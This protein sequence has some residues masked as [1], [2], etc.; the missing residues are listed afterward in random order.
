MLRVVTGFVSH[1]LCSYAFV[2]GLPPDQVYAEV[3][4]PHLNFAPVDWALRYQVD[5]AQ[6]RVRTTLAGAFAGVAQH[7]DGLGCVVVHGGEPWVVATAS[8]ALGPPRLP[9]IAESA[10]VEPSA[11]SLKAALDRAFAE[12]EQPPKRRTKAIVVAHEGRVVAERYAPGYGVDTPLLGFSM[13]KS[14]IN[15]FIG[16][17]VRQGR[18]SVEQPAPVRA[19]RDPADPRRAVTVDQLLRMTSGLAFAETMSGFDPLSQML[20]VERDMADYAARAKLE[21][22]P[23]TRFQ[24]TGCSTLVLSGIVKDAVGGRAFDVLRFARTEL[25]EPLDMR[26]TIIELDSTGTPVGS[27][28]VLAPA[29]DWA[30][31]GLLFLEDGVVG[32]QRILPEGWSRYSSSQTLDTPYGAG[33][34]RGASWGWP[35]DSYVAAGMLAQYVVIVPSER[36]VVVR[37]GLTHREG[38]D[39]GGVGRLL[40]DVIA[41]LR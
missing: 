4:R 34:W 15:A 31:F 37:F 22:E 8:E 32:G 1:T 12:P 40:S 11:A 14:V 41:A 7:R 5:S 27:S 23:G 16:I 39:R 36:L 10:V 35:Y 20:Y 30:R 18:L 25:L 6:R 33:F 28:Y 26:G 9:P 2:S 3:I 38:R 24:Y 13:A 21:A 19:W 29:R 17:L